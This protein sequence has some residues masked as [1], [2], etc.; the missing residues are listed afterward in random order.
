MNPSASRPAVQLA[1]A[2]ACSSRCSPGSRPRAACSCAATSRPRSFTT[3]RV[4]AVDMVTERPVSLQRADRRIRGRGLGRGD[5]VPGRAGAAARACRASGAAG[6][7]RGCWPPGCWST[8]CTRTWSTRCS[9]RTARCSWCTWH[10]VRAGRIR[11]GR[12]SRSTHRPGCA[13]CGG[14]PGAVPAPRGGRPG[15]LHGAA[16]GGHVATDGARVPDGGPWWS[17]STGRRRSWSRRMD[18]GFLVPLGVFTA[19]LAWRR[20]PAGYLLASVVVVKAVAMAS[21]DRGDAARGG[22][23]D[24]G[25]AAAADHHLRD[26]RRSRPPSIGRRV[27]M[28]VHPAGR[29]GIVPAAAARAAAA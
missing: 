26:D 7:G 17:R 5:A 13:G 19:V 6:F 3:V 12:C 4:R 18:L 22:G 29:S 24:R 1:A 16:A 15:R 23:G 2:L 21:R 14:R 10:D 11:P 28:S 27:F 20:A 25:A 9:S 8:S